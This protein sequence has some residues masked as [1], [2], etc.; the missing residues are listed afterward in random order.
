M[1]T[2]FRYSTQVN[3]NG[4]ILKQKDIAGITVS[5]EENKPLEWSI[6]TRPDRARNFAPLLAD[7]YRPAV[8]SSAQV[9]NKP[10]SISVS[11][12]GMTK[13][14]NDLVLWK[15]PRASSYSNYNT[16]FSGTDYSRLLANPNQSM[17]S[18]QS[19]SS[20]IY[21]SNDIIREILPKF[22]VNQS[23]LLPDSESFPL[24][25]CHFQD[26]T[27]LDA[28]LNL[29]EIPVA[30]YRF[31]GKKFIVYLPNYNSSGCDWSY[32]ANKSIFNINGDQNIEEAY[33]R[34][35]VLRT[36]SVAATEL[37]EK[38]GT[39]ACGQKTITFKTNR[40]HPQKRILGR[41]C[42][43][44]V[45]NWQW[46]DTNGTYSD[47][48]GYNGVASGARFTFQQEITDSPVN[49]QWAIEISGVPSE[50]LGLT[51]SFDDA[52]KI[53]RSDYN[54]ISDYGLLEDPD[55]EENPL[56]PNEQWAIKHGDRKLQEYEREIESYTAA[57]KLNPWIKPGHIIRVTEWG[58][59]LSVKRLY[60]TKAVHSMGGQFPATN[61]TLKYCPGT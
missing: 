31:E 18:W 50:F 28:I 45:I 6:A 42:F 35:T 9:I 3:A 41:T 11:I 36:E 26:Q 15:A 12:G 25:V 32:V 57:V 37:H 56:I 4:T 53:T 40:Y 20:K 5:D 48:P 38:I 2:A 27:P 24:R 8:F 13:S 55:S 43:G 46:I 22:G 60:V 59:G 61:L 49:A 58:L 39:E 44:K 10:W 14:W 7:N 34:I 54:R 47:L 17:N 29:I 21:Y 51:S 19:S 52:F 33:N 1:A 23:Q 30:K 16:E